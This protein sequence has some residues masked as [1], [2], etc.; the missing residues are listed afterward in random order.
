MRLSALAGRY[1]HVLLDMDGCLFS[2]DEPIDGSPAA[3]QAL[4]EAGKGVA[5]CTNDVKY[6]PED[7]VRKLW[8]LGFQASIA[9]VVT[10]GAALQHHLAERRSPSTTFVIGTVAIVDHVADAGMRIVNGTDLASRA[11]IVVVAGHPGFDYAELRTAVQAVL[12]GA[13]LIG[14]SR[15]PVYPMPDGPW[16]A[17]GAVLAAVETATGRQAHRVVGKPEPWMYATALDRLAVGPADRVLVVG[18]RLDSDVEGARRAGLDAALVLTGNTAR[19]EADAADP[20][21]THVAASLAALVL[22]SGAGR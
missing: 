8:R 17:T 4:R 6:A 9:E 18:D 14:T 11:E 22:G 10:V 15:D 1:D 5:F 13:E 3:V 12:R 2:G 21:P 16:P 7:Y 20:G 19:E